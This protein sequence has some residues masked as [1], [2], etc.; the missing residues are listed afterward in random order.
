MAVLVPGFVRGGTLGIND[1]A[2]IDGTTS[3]VIWE[4]PPR[5]GILTIQGRCK[6]TPAE[7]QVYTT[8][9]PVDSIGASSDPA[10]WFPVFSAA[11]VADVQTPIHGSVTA[12]KF[13]RTA[14]TIMVG[15]RGQ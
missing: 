1:R 6:V 12:V 15:I 7:F 13:V 11:Q 14:G 8:A 3:E 10:T 4:I 5:I 9:D 2:Q